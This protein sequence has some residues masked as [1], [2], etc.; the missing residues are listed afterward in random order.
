MKRQSYKVIWMVL[1]WAVFLIVWTVLQSNPSATNSF[2]LYAIWGYSWNLIANYA[3]EISLGHSSFAAIG[4][5]TTV[6]LFQKFNIYPIYGWMFGVLA[7]VLFSL[8]IGCFSFRLKGPYFSL[9]TL[10]FSA[11]LL[12][13]ILHFDTVT[14]GANG[15]QIS[16]SS[17]NWANL[18]FLN[19]YVYT[20]IGAI[21]VA[22]LIILFY[23]I[24]RTKFGYYL[25]A[26]KTNSIAAE[27]IGINSFTI[28]LLILV[29]S[30]AFTAIGGI[31]SAF[32][33]GFLDPNYMT[34]LTLATY[35][36]VVPI[37]GGSNFIFGPIIGA[38]ILEGITIF[39]NDLSAQN[40]GYVNACFGLVLMVIVLFA[41]KGVLDLLLRIPAFFSKNKI[42]NNTK[43]VV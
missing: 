19:P 35:M 24:P 14:G 12:S 9:S 10:S 1:G 27:S 31:L 13:L 26:V 43:E 23:F 38:A 5:Y 22:I 4:A 2:V 16:F 11:V 32:S 18:E 15:L 34:G 6:I 17:D 39:T 30:A 42:L 29:L 21:F 8:L 33:V 36:A 37:I 25:Q 41:K 40:A 7:A 28:K 3:G 20:I